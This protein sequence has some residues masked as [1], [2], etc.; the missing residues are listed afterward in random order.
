[1]GTVIFLLFWIGVF[2]AGWKYAGKP[3]YDV[4]FSKKSKSILKNIISDIR[5]EKVTCTYN[6]KTAFDSAGYLFKSTL[7]PTISVKYVSSNEAINLYRNGIPAILSPLQKYILRSEVVT[8]INN[9][10]A[11]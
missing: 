1:M 2:W 4:Y 6:A 7:N 5:A 9:Y 11:D 8:Y 10:H 3:Y